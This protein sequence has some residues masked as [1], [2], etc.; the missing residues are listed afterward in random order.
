MSS[1]SETETST[2]ET[3]RAELIGTD[4]PI[5]RKSRSR[6]KSVADEHIELLEDEEE[7]RS[8]RS[9]S[10]S[11]KSHH[12][13]P[14]TSFGVKNRLE[15]LG[16]IPL[17]WFVNEGTL[18]AVYVATP[19]GEKA[20][21][22]VDSEPRQRNGEGLFQVEG[23]DDPVVNAEIYD[24]YANGLVLKQDLSRRIDSDFAIMTRN[25][26]TIWMNDG[27][28][29]VSWLYKVSEE[30]EVAELTGL[31]NGYFILASAE[32]EQLRE[33]IASGRTVVDRLRFPPVDTDTNEI[34][35]G[36]SVL[37]AL[38]RLVGLYDVLMDEGPF[39]LL[40]PNDIAFANLPDGKVE[41]LM[42][43]ENRHMLAE[44]LEYHIYLGKYNS[45]HLNSK[46]VT[47]EGETIDWG[48]NGGWLMG[49]NAKVLFSDLPAQ[50]GIV[51]ILDTVLIP[52]NPNKKRNVMSYLKPSISF[53]DLDYTT[54]RS[55][56]LFVRKRA[57]VK[58]ELEKAE[59]GLIMELESLRETL[60]KAYQLANRIM[61]KS[62]A[63]NEIS[64]K[65]QFK[66]EANR[67]NRELSVENDKM[68]TLLMEQN[69]IDE[70]VFDMT[71]LTNRIR[72]LRNTTQ[73]TESN[74]QSM[75]N[76]HKMS[77]QQPL[78]PSSQLEQDEMVA[79]AR[80]TIRK[81]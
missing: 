63:Y 41:E 18:Q 67:L 35:S 26:F 21:I 66:E 72:H 59:G 43:P 42:Q 1:L 69:Q 39:T 70:L 56:H 73:E 71:Y 30:D 25:G 51:H 81:D 53:D 15:S 79:E 52:S 68:D 74:T 24:Y 46:L 14:K 37:I 13:E 23:A 65:P 6:S 48:R 77:T 40:A 58:K 12:N 76:S 49:N 9:K 17:V 50:N 44:I 29:Y 19:L 61:N 4:A 75:L 8:P 36:F 62:V 55:R 32:L 28:R 10:R 2:S 27:S 11:S 64:S 78:S 5:A 20:L 31:Y 60:P 57:Q 7:K 80:R 38:L 3:Y 45:S 34:V 16:Y 22:R 33:P 47:A 54:H